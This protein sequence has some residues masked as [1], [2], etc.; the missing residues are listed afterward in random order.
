MSALSLRVLRTTFGGVMPL[1]SSGYPLLDAFWTM[2]LFF[3]WILWFFLLFWIIFDIFRS[4][5]LSGW[6]KAGWL[7]F[8]L[9]LPFLGVFVYSIAR[10]KKM[11]EHQ[12]R[13]RQ[14]K[15]DAMRAYV[16]EAAGS[17]GGSNADELAKLAQLRDQGVLTDQEFAAQKAKLLA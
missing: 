2:L 6:G 15:D 5:D 7:I 16:R 11:T 17:S 12:V 4:D 14:Q 3:L 1:A 13:D 8:V 10:G 9:I